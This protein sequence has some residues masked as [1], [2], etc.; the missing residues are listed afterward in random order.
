M[1]A[2]VEQDQGLRLVS[3]PFVGLHEEVDEALSEKC[4]SIMDVITGPPF[5]KVLYAWRIE[6]GDYRGAASVLHQRL[7]RLKTANV[8][9]SDPQ[10]KSVTDGFLALLNVLSC[11]DEDQAWILSSSRTDADKIGAGEAGKGGGT[12]AKRAKKGGMAGGPQKRQVLTLKNITDEYQREIDRQGLLLHGG[13][14]V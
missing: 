1:E 6:R 8:G 5:H 7:Q 14:F 2:M 9:S 10:A 3:Y 13:F 11:V 4:Q 12:D